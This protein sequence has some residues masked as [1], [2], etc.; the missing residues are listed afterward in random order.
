MI[1]RQIEVATA[2]GAMDTF[3]VCP[4]EGGPF[5]V[6]FL[7]MDAPGV[8]QGLR[9][10]CSRLA[11]CGYMVLMPNLYYRTTRDFVLGPTRDHPDAEAN[12]ARMRAMIAT[13]SNAKVAA[14]VGALLDAAA[15]MREAKPGKVGLVGY[16]MSGAFVTVAAA[17]HPQRIACFA[18][19]YGTRLVTDAAD[20]PHRLLGDI[21]AEGYFSFA[22][23]DHY[24]PL[25]QV[26]AFESHLAAA[27]FKWRSELCK[28]VDHGFAFADRATYDRAAAE[29]HWE[30]M[31]AL[32][33]RHLG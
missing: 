32:F 12:L 8:R 31:L 11:S 17:R 28:G 21:R 27:P 2:D 6:V 7:L 9:D 24:V 33:R 3:A 18:S 13:I 4:D 26:A 5:P 20:S 10:M 23:T 22:E 16:C 30:R 25:D 15:A 1:E 29:R 14:D 19:Y